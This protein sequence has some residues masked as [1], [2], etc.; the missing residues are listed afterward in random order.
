MKS[1]KGRVRPS[2]LGKCIT[3]AAGMTGPVHVVPVKGGSEGTSNLAF[4]PLLQVELAL[5]GSRAS[6]LL[7]NEVDW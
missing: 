7:K 6:G 3:V 1:G 5:H 2:N 4:F